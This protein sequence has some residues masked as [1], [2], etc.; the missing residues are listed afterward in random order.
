MKRHLTILLSAVILSVLGFTPTTVA[1][2][3][4]KDALDAK[5]RSMVAIAALSGVGDLDKLGPAL[6]QGLDAGLTVNEIKEMLVQVYAYAGF[7]RS[8]N[9]I[10]VFQAVVNE[11]KAKGVTDAVGK[12]ASPMPSNRTSL[13]FGTD[14]Q[15]KL[16]G[17]HIAGGIY[18]FVPVIDE[19]L[20]AHLFGDIFQRDV[21]DW[22]QRQLTT[23]SILSGISGVNPQLQGHLGTSLRQGLT[24]DQLR[25][26]ASVVGESLGKAYADNMN[27]LID[28]VVKN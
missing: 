25:G 20:K 14:N 8:L 2:Q 11:R 27:Q 3:N 13:E 24:P 6:N 19:F 10:T 7:P 28:K 15:T 22:K 1:A 26:A 17:R 21:L 18:D 9:A 23:I 16:L 4:V 5:Q 12:I